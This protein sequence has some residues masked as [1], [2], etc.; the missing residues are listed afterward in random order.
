[1]KDRLSPA[2]ADRLVE[3]V[4]SFPMGK[5]VDSEEPTKPVVP[6]PTDK[7]AIVP[8]DKR[9]APESTATADRIRAATGLYRQYCLICHGKDGKGSEFRATMPA[10]P[11][12]TSRG[13]QEKVSNDQIGVS[14]LDGK[15][16]LMPAFSGKVSTQ[17]TRDLTAYVR[18]FGP[19]TTKRVEPEVPAGDFEKQYRELKDQWE[20]LQRQL[21][22]L[23]R[24]TKP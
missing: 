18:A 23:S 20:E 14:I 24:P 6:P 17:Q 5:P 2:D 1:M 7:P 22:E 15:G 3:Y 9:P 8:G 12:F 16:T 13:W 19:A 4:R 21:K 10:L 11:D